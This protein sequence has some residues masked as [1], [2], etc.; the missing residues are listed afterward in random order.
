LSQE[1]T[2]K[3]VGAKAAKRHDKA[4]EVFA[5]EKAENACNTDLKCLIAWKTGK[6]CPSKAS[7]LV[8]IGA[9]NASHI[10]VDYLSNISKKGNPKNKK[11]NTRSAMQPVGYVLKINNPTLTVQYQPERVPLTDVS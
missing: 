5:K 3:V 7:L 2:A 8:W 10:S 11:P 9:K 6:P 4:F 1:E